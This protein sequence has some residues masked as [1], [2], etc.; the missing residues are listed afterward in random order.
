MNIYVALFVVSVGALFWM[1]TGSPASA[2]A[3]LA[4]ADSI[5]GGEPAGLS[6][7]AKKRLK[8]KKH[9]E[10]SKSDDPSQ[11][12]DDEEQRPTDLATPAP[13]PTAEKQ[14]KTSS[15]SAPKHS[16]A[17]AE[18]K[19][20]S[21]PNNEPA[22]AADQSTDTDTVAAVSSTQQTSA[23]VKKQAKS[24]QANRQKHT[25]QIGSFTSQDFPPLAAS[26]AA[27][28]THL[29]AAPLAS[30]S[31]PQSKP[32]SLTAAEIALQQSRIDYG[33]EDRNPDQD[34]VKVARVL[35]V[36]PET[37]VMPLEA[38]DGWQIV[39]VQ[40]RKPNTLRINPSTSS[41]PQRPAARAAPVQDEALTKKQR[42][43][44]RKAER[45]KLQKDALGQVQDDRLAE[46][47]RE[48][49]RLALQK[50][51]DSDKKQQRERQFQRNYGSSTPASSS[52][53]PANEWASAKDSLW[54]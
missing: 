6:K 11:S 43:N 47:R 35:R 27:P 34:D 50:L 8:K 20:K 53:T 31:Q 51:R 5:P 7:S 46:H 29:D 48:Q 3:T 12:L 40:P 1:Y 23:P 18:S 38:E 25:A 13:V 14:S 24:R 33:D 21:K 2:A 17:S 26:A 45:V 22:I 44:K 52:K 37:P 30:A 15:K 19:A 9:A 36:Q 42:E 32:S 16:K 10:A 39:D 49:E 41:A 4:R 28:A 54:D